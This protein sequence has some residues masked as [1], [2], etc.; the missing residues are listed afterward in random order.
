MTNK[1]ENLTR[2]SSI[3]GRALFLPLGEVRRGL[4]QE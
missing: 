4:W 2:S 1:I 3:S